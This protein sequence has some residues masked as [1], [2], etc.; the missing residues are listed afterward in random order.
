MNPPSLETDT[1]LERFRRFRPGGTLWRIPNAK[2]LSEE[3]VGGMFNIPK[4][5]KFTKMENP[6]DPI[7]K[8]EVVVN[9]YQL[10]CRLLYL[11][12]S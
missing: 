10:A 2:F 12:A 4:S 1:D 11:R 9:L 7:C 6:S 5:V 3:E 8:E